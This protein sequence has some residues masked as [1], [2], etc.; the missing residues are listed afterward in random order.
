[1][2]PSQVLTG[3][4]PPTNPP[5]SISSVSAPLVA[6]SS[7]TITWNTNENSDSQVD[8]GLTANYGST[9]S[10]N[11]SMV[12]SHNQELSGLTASTQYHSRVKSKDATGILATS[13]DFSFTTSSAPD[14][15]PPTI[16]GVGV[17]SI[18]SSSATIGWTTNENSDSQ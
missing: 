3:T 15:T 13:T 1:K 10:I 4:V 6:S 8:Y 14:T 16:N 17:S 9:T 7:A 12:T 18:T 11:S 2:I 5:L